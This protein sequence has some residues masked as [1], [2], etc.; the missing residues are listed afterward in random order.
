LSSKNQNSFFSSSSFHSTGKLSSP[1]K[2]A[3]TSLVE[4]DILKSP[5]ELN[6]VDQICLPPALPVMLDVLA[7]GKNGKNFQSISGK[8]AGETFKKIKY[9][10]LMQQSRKFFHQHLPS[11]RLPPFPENLMRFCL[12]IKIPSLFFHRLPAST[13]R[14]NRN[15]WRSNRPA[16][17]CLL[18]KKSGHP[19]RAC[20]RE[21]F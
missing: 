8:F 7:P 14:G 4:S 10:L 17:G 20:N 12:T 19:S 18:Q 16:S 1:K 5:C 3:N 6:L 2:V 13:Q 9:F 15:L 21:N 11:I